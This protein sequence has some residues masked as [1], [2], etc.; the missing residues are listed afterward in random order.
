MRQPLDRA[1]HVLSRAAK[2]WYHAFSKQERERFPELEVDPQTHKKP[3]GHVKLAVIRRL[4]RMLD[5]GGP[6]VPVNSAGSIPV[7]STEPEPPTP[8]EEFEAELWKL[9]AS[10]GTVDRII[11]LAQAAYT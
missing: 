9:G 1:E 7:T 6:E 2:D 3:A 10:P 8:A 4:Q 5:E 11:E